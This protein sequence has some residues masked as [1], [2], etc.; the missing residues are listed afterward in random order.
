MNFFYSVGALVGF[1]FAVAGAVELVPLILHAL[2]TRF[3]KEPRQ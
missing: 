1:A 3:S 2:K